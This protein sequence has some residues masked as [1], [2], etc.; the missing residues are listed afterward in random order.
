MELGK[1]TKNDVWSSLEKKVKNKP[2][3]KIMAEIRYS[4]V[5][6]RFLQRQSADKKIPSVIR[7]A[8]LEY[9]DCFWAWCKGL[10]LD[11]FKN[12]YIDRPIDGK[13]IS[14]EDLGFWIQNENIHCQTGM[15]RGKES[16]IYLWHTEEEPPDESFVTKPLLVDFLI[17][18]VLRT[19]YIHPLNMP[20]TG[21]GWQKNFFHV[22]NSYYVYDFLKDGGSL[23][24]CCCWVLWRLGLEVDSKEIIRALF[25]FTDGCVIYTVKEYEGTVI[26]QRYS[27]GIRHLYE[28]ILPEKASSY[29][30]QAT[31]VRDAPALVP[32]EY[33]TKK[34]FNKYINRY[35]R[36]DIFLK[37][38][39]KNGG[40][41]DVSLAKLMKNRWGGSFSYC[42][43]DVKM[44][45]ISKFMPGKHTFIYD[46][47]P[48]LDRNNYITISI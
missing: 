21:F 3:R 28:D 44:H 5:C 6:Y 33:V 34:S 48:A 32:Y 20:A 1:M 40:I 13:R 11:Q 12:D 36:N 46:A 41:D 15:V 26:G 7:A 9:L 43:E 37:R 31:L 30:F 38:L 4:R 45:F 25:P 17:K 42:N 2:Q 39:E 14:G 47:G 10:N 19:S 27:F 16:A 24:H 18:G 23:A 29:F 35:K 22:M 8:L